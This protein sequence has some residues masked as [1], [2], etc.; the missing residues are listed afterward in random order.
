MNIV[1]FFEVMI[2]K[3]QDLIHFCNNSSSSQISE[4]TQQYNKVGKVSYCLTIIEYFG[5][6]LAFH[7]L[8][9]CRCR[10]TEYEISAFT[11]HC[12]SVCHYGIRVC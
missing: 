6:F 10:R 3:E 9:L 1:S 8:E 12:E 7:L 5:V 11:N 2:I 4:S